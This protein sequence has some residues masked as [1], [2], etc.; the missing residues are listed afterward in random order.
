MIQQIFTRNEVV[1]L[2]KEILEN[3]DSVIDL[4]ENENSNHDAE[5]LLKDAVNYC[6]KSQL[7]KG[8][9]LFDDLVIISSIDAKSKEGKF[10][11]NIAKMSIVNL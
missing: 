3:P 10:C 6:D 11:K 7:K 5:S 9:S 8:Q 2:I 4:I 1:F